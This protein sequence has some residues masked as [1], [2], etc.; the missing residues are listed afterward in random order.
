MSVRIE[1]RKM[2]RRLQR[3]ADAPTGE[4]IVAELTA[5]GLN[6]AKPLAQAVSPTLGQSIAAEPVRTQDGV[7]TGGFGT[8]LEY[9]PYVEFGT[10]RPG[11]LGQI[12]N[13]QPRNPAADGFAFTL[14]TVIR[15]GP[16]AGQ[17]RPG[18][19]YHSDT[20][21]FVHTLGQ[22]AAPFMYPAQKLLE[23]EAG[24]IAGVVIRDSIRG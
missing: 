19:V 24:Q 13:A 11:D 10:G 15:S 9:A 20:Y 7:V 12:K 16:Q 18:W 1:S 23:E 17:L 5:R 21:G 8:N 2:E 4:R 14:Q 6:T 22:P 3:M